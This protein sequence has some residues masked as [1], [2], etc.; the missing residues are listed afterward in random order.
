MDHLDFN[1]WQRICTITVPYVNNANP[2]VYLYC[3][4]AESP[5]PQQNDISNTCGNAN[6]IKS[7][8]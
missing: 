7:N 4:N 8:T 3:V 6:L 5:K 2:D 1:V